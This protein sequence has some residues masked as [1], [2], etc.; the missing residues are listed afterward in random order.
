MR[1]DE[2]SGAILVGGGA[3]RLGGVPKGLYLRDGEPIVARL[4][5]ALG[6]VARD[7]RLVADDPSPYAALGLP[8]V[9]DAIAG[10]GPAGGLLAA[11]ESATTPWVLV[12]AGDMPAVAP[13]V[14]A[15]LRDRDARFDCVL[16]LVDGR[17]EPLC[18]R[19]AARVA[20]LVRRA[21][22][23]GERALH[24]LVDRVDADRVGE[25][26][27]RAVDPTLRSLGSVNTPADVAAWDLIA[28]EGGRSGR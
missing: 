1:R 13:A 23:E 14:L 18:A 8:S 19:W 16:P 7:V 15:L 25:D 17:L 5:R 2:A 21:I 3:R 9:P 6:A 12:V 28:P 22:E 24:A 20:P 26:E 4:A 27:L 10:V 11:L